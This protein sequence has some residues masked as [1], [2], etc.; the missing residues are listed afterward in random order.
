MANQ[1]IHLGH[2]KWFLKKP[3]RRLA[4]LSAVLLPAFGSAFCPEAFS[5]AV[6]EYTLGFEDY[7][8]GT[9]TYTYGTIPAG[10]A[11]GNYTYQHTFQTTVGTVQLATD[12]ADWSVLYPGWGY[13]P[14]WSFGGGYTISN[15]SAE[16]T[17][18]P[19]TVTNSGGMTEANPGYVYGVGNEYSAVAGTT[20]YP[21]ADYG[22]TVGASSGSS[23]A[24]LFGSSTQSTFSSAMTFENPVSLKSLD[25]TNTA[26]VLAVETFGNEFAQQASS[27]NWAAAILQGWD[28]EGNQVGQKVLMLHDYLVGESI[29]TD[30][31]TV[32]LENLTAKVY[33]AAYYGVNESDADYQQMVEDVQN[34]IFSANGIPYLA[35]LGS[36]SDISSLTFTFNG[37]DAGNWGVNFPTYLALDNLILSALADD[38]GVDPSD[39]SNPVDPSNPIIP[40][41]GM[42]SA[43]PEPSSWLLLLSGAG[44]G[45]GA[46]RRKKRV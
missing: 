43:V 13:E 14:G 4:I 1:S 44:L 39:P 34:G 46:Y 17:S 29:V 38:P 41:P 21:A 35:D 30:W 27:D 37:S 8:T 40:G 18:N 45:I 7:L 28:A 36:F 32:N 2:L 22:L 3:F 31:T 23:Y 5:A 12:F 10:T 16:N 42:D 26:S 20:N 25:F 11:G 24:V 15:I 9:N 33:D 19:R 6:V